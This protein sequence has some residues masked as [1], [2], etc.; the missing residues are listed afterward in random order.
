M[1]LTHIA[2][3]S[4]PIVSWRPVSIAILTF[5]PTPSFA[6]TRMGSRKPAAFR[7]KSPPKPPISASAPGRRVER[8]SG[9]M[10]STMALPA[11]MSTPAWA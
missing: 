3:R 11:S 1:S 9:L 4:I 2:T 5:V 8:T 6:A 7:S 10:A